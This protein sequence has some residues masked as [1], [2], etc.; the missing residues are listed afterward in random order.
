MPKFYFTFGSDDHF[1]Y[2]F[3]EYVE[4]EA[5]DENEARE[6]FRVIWPNREDSPFLNC[7]SVYDEHYWKSVSEK[8]YKNVKP[9]AVVRIERRLRERGSLENA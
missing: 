2:E 3:H 1:P 8:Y 5:R 6:V 9:A 7:A 4:I